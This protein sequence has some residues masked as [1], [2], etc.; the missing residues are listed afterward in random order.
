MAHAARASKIWRGLESRS[1]DSG[2][3]AGAIESLLDETDVVVNDLRNAEAEGR[4]ERVTKAKITRNSM[5]RLA[6]S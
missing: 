4:L 6:R 5:E 3:C 2:Y 1:K